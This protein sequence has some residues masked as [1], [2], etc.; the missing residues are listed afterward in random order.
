MGTTA[1]RE[2]ARDWHRGP[3]RK[4]APGGAGS[5][6]GMSPGRPKRRGESRCHGSEMFV[7]SRLINF[8]IVRIRMRDKMRLARR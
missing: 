3:A 2:M 8:K 5:E 4:G 1:V 6:G 7:D